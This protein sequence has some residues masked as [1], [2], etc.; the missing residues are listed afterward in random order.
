MRRH[1]SVMTPGA[2]A[3]LPWR[4]GYGLEAALATNGTSPTPENTTNLKGPLRLV[5]G[6]V[7][8]LPGC[9][10]WTRTAKHCKGVGEETATGVLN[11]NGLVASGDS[12]VEMWSTSKNS[13]LSQRC[14]VQCGSQ[15]Q[16][17]RRGS[18][19]N[20]ISSLF[21]TLVFQPSV[22]LEVARS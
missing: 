12:V 17:T 1:D 16:L 3:A 8:C 22:E 10:P 2:D 14:H 4:R 20:W 7:L 19:R 9:R 13:T 5:C 18:H 21:G 11:L 6:Q 15:G